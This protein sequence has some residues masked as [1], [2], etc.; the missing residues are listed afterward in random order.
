MKLFAEMANHE[1]RNDDG[2]ILGVVST[3]VDGASSITK[4]CDVEPDAMAP[5]LTWT[6]FASGAVIAVRPMVFAC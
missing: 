3:A 2:A 6:T 5:D 4:R 1:S